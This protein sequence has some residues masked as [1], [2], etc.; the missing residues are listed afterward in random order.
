MFRLRRSLCDFLSFRM[1]VLYLVIAFVHN[2]FVSLSDLQLTVKLFKTG[3]LFGK[4]VG[5]FKGLAIYGNGFI[6][7]CLHSCELVSNISQLTVKPI[8]E[9]IFKAS[10]GLQ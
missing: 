2:N 7:V 8:A 9:Q 4:F 10:V 5:V 1:S 6:K 3:R